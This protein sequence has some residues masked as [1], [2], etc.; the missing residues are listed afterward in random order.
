MTGPTVRVNPAE[1]SD[2]FTRH[3]ST[4]QGLA[5]KFGSG[6]P[7]GLDAT[8]DAALAS[9]T[10]MS[11]GRIENI[12]QDVGKSDAAAQLLGNKD[13][14]NKSK[15]DAVP[16]S[17]ED[18]NRPGGKGDPGAKGDRP[19]SP[20]LSASDIA[21]IKGGPASPYQSSMPTSQTAPGTPFSPGSF[22]PGSLLSGL[23]GA[24]SPIQSMLGSPGSSALNPGSVTPLMGQ[25]LSQAKA[26]G[27]MDGGP[28]SL[29]IG[30]SRPGDDGR[31]QELVKGALGTT[32]A[33]G[34][35][36]NNG[37]SQ[38]ITD[39]GGPADAAGD[40]KKIGYDCSGLSKYVTY[41]AFGV[42][43]P[44]TTW[45][46]INV[47][48]AVTLAEARIGDLVFPSDAKG[49]H[50]AVYMGTDAG[51]RALMAEAPSSGQTVKISPLREGP[52]R[53]YH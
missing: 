8:I 42:D 41:Q 44:R 45:D 11:K 20:R 6:H 17:A 7:T 10:E 4:L 25:L 24:A 14:E 49:G 52:M 50:V 22:N 19:G 2:V 18:P 51:G 53:T 35:G 48:R 43:L 3:Q 37:P 13:G 32:Y 40:Y 16:G 33:W 23:G 30:P 34:G 46:Q 29:P 36:G 47:G 15:V 5:S 26:N 38:G 9:R 39:H 31:V 12:A 21:N 1:A 28:A 27:T